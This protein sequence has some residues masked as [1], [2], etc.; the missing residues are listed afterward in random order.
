VPGN[1]AQAI[2]HGLERI[3]E[4]VGGLLGDQ[5]IEH[6][7]LVGEGLEQGLRNGLRVIPRIGDVEEIV[8]EVL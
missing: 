8:V 2:P 7:S 1:E 6:G 3:D 5:G 4:G